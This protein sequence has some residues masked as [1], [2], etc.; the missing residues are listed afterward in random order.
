VEVVCQQRDRRG[1]VEGYAA[2]ILPGTA[3]E[4]NDDEDENY[5]ENSDD[6]RNNHNHCLTIIGYGYEETVDRNSLQ[7][8]VDF[9]DNRNSNEDSPPV[10]VT[11]LF[12]SGIYLLAPSD[13]GLNV[14]RRYLAGND[15]TLTKISF[16]HCIFGD[17][18]E[19]SQL[20]QALHTN[21][22]ITII[23]IEGWGRG[24]LKSNNLGTAVGGLMINMPQLQEVE[25]SRIMLRSAGLRGMQ[26]G[27]RTNQALKR[28]KL[29]C[30]GLEDGSVGL[31][32]DA[33]VG[34][35]TMESLELSTFDQ[36][37]IDKSS[38]DGIIRMINTTQLQKILF[39][40]RQTNDILNDAAATVQ[41][42][43]AIQH[44]VKVQA[45]CLGQQW[46]HRVASNDQDCAIK[47]DS[48]NTVTIKIHTSW[49]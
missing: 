13:G 10:A 2:A 7:Y 48:A 20:L 30:C 31:L 34:N 27:L 4:D 17:L 33:L 12:L 22:T 32:S 46:L 29:V 47:M 15:M 5:S 35:T 45:L 6:N 14:L 25:L 23:Q 40:P 8:L 41:I 21:R 37:V 44:N 16:N 24:Q 49:V 38:T 42:A 11:N 43:H 19:Y 36:N 39:S 28:L 1:G 9:L 3:V 26:P 18:H